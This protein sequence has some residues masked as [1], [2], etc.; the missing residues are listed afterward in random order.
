M[1]N[2]RSVACIVA[3]W[4]CRTGMCGPASLRLSTDVY[5]RS[6]VL[7]GDSAGSVTGV[8]VGPSQSAN[9]NPA[10]GRSGPMTAPGPSPCACPFKGSTGPATE[11]RILR[12]ATAMIEDL[13]PEPARVPVAVC[14]TVKF[15]T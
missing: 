6:G 4:H 5:R 9:L 11:C 15:N 8:G 3:A 10:P 12:V 14:T 2:A 1:A 13:P 7:A